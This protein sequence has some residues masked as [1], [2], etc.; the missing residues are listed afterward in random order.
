[1]QERFWLASRL[2]VALAGLFV[3]SSFDD[4]SRASR[5]L[6]GAF[7]LTDCPRLPMFSRSC[8]GK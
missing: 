6:I 4:V 5:L 3:N 7:Y 1:M 8:I 2:L